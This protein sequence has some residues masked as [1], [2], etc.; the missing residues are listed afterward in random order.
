[1][2]GDT[3]ANAAVLLVGICLVV[4]SE[5]V[6]AIVVECIRHPLKKTRLDLNSYGGSRVVTH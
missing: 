2:V 6:R 4:A 1:M 5:S 3:L